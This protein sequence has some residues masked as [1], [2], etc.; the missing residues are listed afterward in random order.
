[1]K[2]FSSRNS[3]K[4]YLLVGSGGMVG[5]IARYLCSSYF[6]HSYPNARFPWGTFVVNI[7]GCLLIG[8]LAGIVERST[9]YNAELR[10][11]LITG[12][13]GGFTTFSAFGIESL[14]LIR[15]NAF[16]LA[17]VYMLSSTVLGVAAAFIGIKLGQP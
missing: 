4:E 5:A 9:H 8:L 13:L 15:A 3:M 17:L 16:C 2:L 14:H 7:L 6:L 11:L 12:F 1:M 10:L